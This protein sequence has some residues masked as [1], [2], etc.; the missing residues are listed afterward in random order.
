MNAPLL[1]LYSIT[2][3]AGRPS[4]VRRVSLG[5]CV[6]ERP[7]KKETG[8]EEE[9]N[10]NGRVMWSEVAKKGASKKEKSKISDAREG[11]K[12]RR[13]WRIRNDEGKGGEG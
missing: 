7:S 12:K 10:K 5:G 8:E 13:V 2:V 3:P 1:L 6:S 11:T 9:I 4:T